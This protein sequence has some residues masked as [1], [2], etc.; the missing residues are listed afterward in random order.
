[1]AKSGTKWNPMADAA[2]ES[3]GME[4]LGGIDREKTAQS[5]RYTSELEDQRSGN[6][7]NNLLAGKA[8]DR[9]YKEE[10]TDREAESLR[11]MLAGR[12]DAAKSLG[13]SR[14]GAPQQDAVDGG[15]FTP[16]K[17]EGRA[18][19]Y[20]E[21][22]GLA[23]GVPGIAGKLLDQNLK[24]NDPY[25]LSEGQKRFNSDNQMVA[26]NPKLNDPSQQ[27]FSDAAAARADAVAK[28]F[29]P[30]RIT[31]KQDSHGWTYSTGVTESLAE[32]PGKWLADM[33]DPKK[34][35]EERLRAK[36]MLEQET[37]RQKDIAQVKQD[38]LPVTGDDRMRDRKSV[39]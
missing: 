2:G 24:G 25:S 32:G 26:E 36:T 38:V 20:E 7:L 27:R 1:M 30:A 18:P 5:A 29:D 23:R 6:T 35:A 12:P 4:R 31:I 14:Q 39:V 22:R 15:V 10:D 34:S 8:Q 13:F 16:G 17:V 28:G 19:T 9:A 33:N 37:A 11:S 21:A 3:Y